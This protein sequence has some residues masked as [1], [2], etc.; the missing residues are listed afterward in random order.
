MRSCQ[1][2]TFRPV[3]EGLEPREVPTTLHGSTSHPNP[4]VPAPGPAGGWTVRH[5]RFVFRAH[6]GG[7]KI[8]F[9]GDSLTTDWQGTGRVAW[10]RYF[11]PLGAAD[12]G[13]AGDT[14][15]TLLW[16]INNGELEG[17]RPQVVVLLIGT[18]NLG[19]AAAGPVADGIIS[20]TRALHTYLPAAR[21]LLLGILPRGGPAEAALRGEI[22]A[23]NQQLARLSGPHVRFLD[24]GGLFAGA[25]GAPRPDL[26]LPD[27]VHLSAA[28]YSVLGQALGPAA[29]ALMTP[30]GVTPR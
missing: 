14:T 18:N 1:P 13:I 15:Q 26:F 29:K 9:L 24:L 5:T 3:V 23:I 10:K 6:Q 28:G 25:D 12:F 2:R 7:I 27:F 21:I 11:S 16:R 20:I 30:G 17:I 4:V 19:T 22:G 8:L